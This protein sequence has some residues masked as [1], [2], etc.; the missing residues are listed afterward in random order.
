MAL[1][2][3]VKQVKK[4]FLAVIQCQVRWIL[5]H[6]LCSKS[7]NSNAQKTIFENNIHYSLKKKPDW[8]VDN[9][10]IVW[11]GTLFKPI[12]G[13]ME[14]LLPSKWLELAIKIDPLSYKS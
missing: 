10:L 1:E 9:S 4:K 2:R 8:M 3:F 13:C 5:H 6:Q 12:H 7:N 11:H 14:L